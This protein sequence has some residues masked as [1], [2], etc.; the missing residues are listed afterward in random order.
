MV[1]RHVEL[2]DFLPRQLNPE[3]P[4]E[5]TSLHRVFLSTAAAHE[6]KPAIF[7]GDTEVRYRQLAA[8]VQQIGRALTDRHG[9]IPGE[10]VALWHHNAPDFVAAWYGI[11]AAG[12]VVV[13]INNFLKPAEIAHILRDAGIRLLLSEPELIASAAGLAGEFPELKLVA[14][15]DLLAAPAGSSGEPAVRGPE[16]LAVIIYTSGTTGRPKGAMLS[17][18]NLLHNVRSCEIVLEAV[19]GDRLAVLLPLFH[20]F[21]MTVGMVLPLSVGGS[22][23]LIRSLN[24]PKNA[25]LEIIRHQATILPAVP[26]FFRALAGAGLKDGLPLRLCVSG[27]APLPGEI[28]REF[29]AHMSMPLIEGYGLSETSPVASLNPIHGQRKAGSIGLPIHDVEMAVWDEA[30]NALADR[31]TGEI[32]I[33]GGNVMQGYWNQP[34][35]TAQALQ[36]GWLRTGDVGYRDEEGYY[37]ITDRKKDMLLVNGI[38]V[39][40]REI[41]EV[42]YQFPGVR[43]AAVIGRTDARRGEMPI[44]FG[45]RVEGRHIDAKSL[46]AFVKERLADYKVPRKI[47]ELP[48][49][50]RT[51]TGK[52]LKTALR[53]HAVD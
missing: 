45:A 47:I 3:M 36:N 24:P 50:P 21:M 16:D 39:Y 38:N 52:I 14:V 8:S 33:R 12:G 42:I 34:E 10:R 31:E 49:L 23:V 13:P 7:W 18:G 29:E 53:E 43:E 6:D 48:A 17:H 28:L 20:S 37:Y 5:M 2:D 1:E 22:M 32:V 40:P 19:E 4:I 9:V 15:T 11:L 51:A 44:A 41:E 35:A 26:Q 30:G 27:G 46:T 25:I